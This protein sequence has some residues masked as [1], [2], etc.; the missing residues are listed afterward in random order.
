[1]EGDNK[2]Y[3][4]I[5]GT[6]KK[7]KESEISSNEEGEFFL[8]EARK[9]L[10]VEDDEINIKYI[11]SIIKVKGLFCVCD[12]ANNGKMAF[13]MAY[14]DTYDLILMDCRMPVLDGYESTKLIR[15]INERYANIPIIGVTAYAHEYYLEKCLAS[16]MDEYIVKPF[17]VEQI[18][19]IILK[20]IDFKAK[21]RVLVSI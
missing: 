20:Y 2:M 9:I 3:T 11:T 8:D 13:E 18:T 7:I 12:I 19:D 21:S 5:N 6:D 14:E 17:S 15:K 4:E 10:L 16:G 1:M